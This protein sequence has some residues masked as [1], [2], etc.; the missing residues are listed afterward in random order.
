MERLKM[1]RNNITFIEQSRVYQ[2][3]HSRKIDK[4]E[5]LTSEDVL[6]PDQKRRRE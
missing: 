4:N 2:H 6:P 5:Y 3:Y 1:K